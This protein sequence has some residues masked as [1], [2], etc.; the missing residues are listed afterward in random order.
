MLVI[1]LCFTFPS[2][3]GI[4]F[5]LFPL[6]LFLFR[7]FFSVPPLFP[8][9]NFL[10]FHFHF[11][12]F[13]SRVLIFFFCLYR[14]FFSLSSLFHSVLLSFIVP[15]VV[16]FSLPISYYIYLSFFLSIVFLFVFL[17]YI[18]PEYFIMTI[19]LT[20]FLIPRVFPLRL[21]ASRVAS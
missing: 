17:L 12:L 18:C 4:S 2:F 16:S 20:L 3:F 6:Y 14:P 8:I 7:S 11:F 1:L 15:S 9:I 10:Y 13:L 19:T 21:W 5:S